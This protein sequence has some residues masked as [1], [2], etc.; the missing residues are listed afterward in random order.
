MKR[1]M[2]FI[3]AVA[4]AGVLAAPA[5][6]APKPSIED[7]AGDANLLNDQGTGGGTPGDVVTPADGSSFADLLSVTFTNDKKNLYVH[8]ET[9]STATPVA[10][11]GFRV[12]T[13]PDGAGGIY[14]LNF[15]IFFPGAQNTVTAPVAHLRDACAGGDAIEAEATFST[16]GGFM[17]VVPRKSHEGLGKGGKLTAPQAQSFLY[18]GPHPTGVAGPYFDTTTAGTDYALKK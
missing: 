15:E 1:S 14:C 18:S 2:A 8:I 6:G 5:N 12:R 9:E 13:N 17:I 3:T 7:V 10:G 16:L 11:E 4:I